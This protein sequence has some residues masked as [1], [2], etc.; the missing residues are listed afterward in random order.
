MADVGA[1]FKKA[2]P[3]IS[4]ALSFG[5][6]AGSI[7]GKLLSGVTGAT[8]PV[9][10]LEDLGDLFVKSPDQQ[11][12]VQDLKTAENNFQLQLQ[13][14]N[15]QSLDDLEKM[16]VDDRTSARQMQ[17]ST[18]SWTAPLL[19]WFVILSFAFCVWAILTGHG[20]V[21]AAFAG[22]LIGYLAANANQVVSYYFGSSAGSDRK[23]E[24][25][26]NGNGQ[27]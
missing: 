19:A 8:G 7:A 11:K 24:I 2:V 20:K 3:W 6:P 10:S 14:L 12:F 26:A 13:Q 16:A 1:F 23:T 9:N 5:G 15:I 27:H 22:T 18:K 25:L 4:T 21:E 17:V